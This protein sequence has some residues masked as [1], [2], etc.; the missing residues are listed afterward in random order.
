[1]TTHPF[2]GKWSFTMGGASMEG[3]LLSPRNQHC[4]SCIGTLSYPMLTGMGMNV[5]GM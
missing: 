1:M 3:W 2:C 4:A 5:A